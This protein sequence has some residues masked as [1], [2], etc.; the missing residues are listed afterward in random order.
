[1]GSSELEETGRRSDTGAIVIRI[2][3]VISA[4]PSGD[5]LG[6]HQ[7]RKLGWTPTTTLEE[8]VCE[9]IRVDKEEARKEAYL[10]QKGFE[11]V[12]PRE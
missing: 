7:C 1:M 3:L 6:D 5:L 11:I 8:L 12:G 10:K 9:M 4:R 2:D